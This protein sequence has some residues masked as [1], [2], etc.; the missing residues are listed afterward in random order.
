MSFELTY[1]SS[2]N[3]NHSA[4]MTIVLLMLVCQLIQE[5]YENRVKEGKNMDFSASP[6]SSG[7]IS[8]SCWSMCHNGE[9]ISEELLPSHLPI[10]RL[11]NL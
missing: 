5:G 3:V 4:L 6:F 10:Y 9:I 1:P 8:Q 2:I 7:E 11:E